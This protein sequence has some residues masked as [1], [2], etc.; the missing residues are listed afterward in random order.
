MLRALG[1]GL[2]ASLALACEQ[3]AP[4]VALRTEAPAP[5]DPQPATPATLNL[6]E[7][8]PTQVATPRAIPTTPVAVHADDAATTWPRDVADAPTTPAPTAP[9]PAPT[10][11]VTVAPASDEGDLDELRAWAEE[12]LE[13][14]DPDEALE[15]LDLLDTLDSLEALDRDPSLAD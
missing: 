9:A 2:L 12:A 8:P 3:P 7:E 15:L 6:P 4:P 10:T 5:A 1:L 14:A 13:T 11:P